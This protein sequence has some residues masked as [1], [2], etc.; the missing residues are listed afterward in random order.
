MAAIAVTA[1]TGGEDTPTVSLTDEVP[2]EYATATTQNGQQRDPDA[3]SSKSDVNYQ[4]QTNE[5]QQCSGCQFYIPDKNGD[6]IGACAIVEGNITPD[7]WCVSYVAAEDSDIREHIRSLF[8]HTLNL[9]PGVIV[10]STCRTAK[11]HTRS[12]SGAR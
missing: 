8:R 10:D 5:G 12:R 3:L 9:R 11:R 1:T 6:G 7:A 2:S 4:E